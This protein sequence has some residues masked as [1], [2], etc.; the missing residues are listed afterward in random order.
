MG[1]TVKYLSIVFCFPKRYGDNTLYIN[2]I[3]HLEEIGW[4]KS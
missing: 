1:F 3:M 2:Q 4:Q